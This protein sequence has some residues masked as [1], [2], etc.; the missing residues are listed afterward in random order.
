MNVKCCKTCKTS[1]CGP[2]HLQISSHRGRGVSEIKHDFH[3]HLE[4]FHSIIHYELAKENDFQKIHIY[5]QMKWPKEKRGPIF[6]LPY[7]SRD[8]NR[9]FLRETECL[10]A[11]ERKKLIFLRNILTVQ[12]ILIEFRKPLHSIQK[13]SKLTA[14]QSKLLVNL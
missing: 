5:I 10:T 12:N 7:L 11:Q 14:L 3:C 4:L 1:Q 8:K 6:G 9:N 2:I 13:T